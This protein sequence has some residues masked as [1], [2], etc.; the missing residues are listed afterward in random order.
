MTKEVTI[1]FR[2]SAEQ[3]MKLLQKS[4]AA[5]MKLTNYIELLVL[6]G[7]DRHCQEVEKQLFTAVNENINEPITYKDWLSDELL[8]KFEKHLEILK[9]RYPRYTDE[10]LITACVLHAEQ[11]YKAFVQK[12]LKSFLKQFKEIR[13]DD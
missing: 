2:V 6:E 3:K 9:K 10:T 13:D 11:N 5:G 1:S 7:F 8:L 12:D 4:E